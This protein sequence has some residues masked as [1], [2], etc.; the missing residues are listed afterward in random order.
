MKLGERLLKYC[1]D[2][3]V[4]FSS[5]NKRILVINHNAMQAIL[6][7]DKYSSLI[8]KKIADRLGPE[9]EQY[10]IL[11]ECVSCGKKFAGR[12]N[13]RCCSAKCSRIYSNNSRAEKDRLSTKN[14]PVRNKDGNTLQEVFINYLEEK[15]V[16]Y[17]IIANEIKMSHQ[18]LNNIKL[19]NKYSDYTAKLLADYLGAPFEVFPIRRSCVVCGDSYYSKHQNSIR[20]PECSEGRLK[21]K[22]QVNENVRRKPDKGISET[23][24]LAKESEKTYG[25][26]VAMERL[27][28]GG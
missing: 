5:L 17:R 4:S 6:N 27:S 7:D 10:I 21:A 28:Q 16:S 9:F 24:L 18:T 26:Y 3:E 13:A 1:K 8:A 23:A 15:D 12:L 20:C 22:K 2:N 14:P 25:Y 11:N 19:Y